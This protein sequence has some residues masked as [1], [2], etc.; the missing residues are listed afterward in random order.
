M[1][2]KKSLYINGTIA[3]QALF[4]LFTLI[5]A[6]V[7][8]YLTNHYFDSLFATDLSA[9]SLCNINEYFNCDHT[10]ASPF[11]NI[12]GVPI[13]LLGL[14]FSL[15]LFVGFFVPNKKAVEG[16]NHFL[17]ILNVVGCLFL[18]L[19]SIIGLGGIC[20]GCAVYYLFSVLSFFILMKNSSYRQL[21]FK[22]LGIYAVIA[23]AISA[24]SLAHVKSKTGEEEK[25]AK[26]LIAQ[27]D[28]LAIVG[29]PKIDSEYRTASATDKFADAPIRITKF[30]DYECP[31]CRGLAHSLEKVAEKYKGFVNIQY[32]FF[33]LDIAC[34]PTMERAL[35]EYACSAAYLAACL[36]DKFT[37]ITQL[38]FNKKTV[39]SPNWINKT[40][41]KYGVEKCLNDKATKEKVVEYINRAKDYNITGT[42]T[43]I[44]NG[45][46]ITRMLPEKQLYYLLDHLIKGKSKAQ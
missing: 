6:G 35:H 22:V 15:F 30:S 16:T 42:P 7:S 8:I 14:L 17:S 13:S 20:P 24:L 3:N 29:D 21:D 27:F 37:E 36:K 23:L 19:Y 45:K 39:L 11:S 31:G 46:K 32:S 4:G 1:S 41:K 28:S 12:L 44:L 5:M 26:S 40:A 38:I 10:I 2:E 43:M 34:N 33:P 18:L 25:I 9:D